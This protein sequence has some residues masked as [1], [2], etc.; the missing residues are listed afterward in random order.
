MKR[1]IFLKEIHPN[2]KKASEGIFIEDSEKLPDSIKETVGGRIVYNVPIYT[3]IKCYTDM[4]WNRIVTTPRI[5]GFVKCGELSGEYNPD[6]NMFL[7]Q[8][9]SYEILCG[10]PRRTPLWR[11]CAIHPLEKAF[12]ILKFILPTQPGWIWDT[13]NPD[14]SMRA[15]IVCS[16]NEL[17]EILDTHPDSVKF[18]PRVVDQIE[19][20]ITI[21]AYTEE[22]THRGD[23]A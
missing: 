22:E 16:S 20:L 11:L 5:E 2:P 13:V 4:E 10:F 12:R 6:F 21:D 23:K 1:K 3:G 17:K 19:E 18:V 14:Y 7:G 15:L 9:V 8:P